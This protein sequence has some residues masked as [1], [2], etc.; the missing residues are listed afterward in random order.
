MH[1]YLTRS[2]ENYK[3]LYTLFKGINQTFSKEQFNKGYPHDQCRKSEE[4]MFHE[5]TCSV[6]NHRFPYPETSG[7]YH[8]IDTFYFRNI[9]HRCLPSKYRH[10]YAA[11]G[12]WQCQSYHD[13]SNTNTWII[14]RDCRI[15][16]QWLRLWRAGSF[17]APC[18]YIAKEESLLAT[19]WFL[20]RYPNPSPVFWLLLFLCGLGILLNQT[21]SIYTITPASNPHVHRIMIWR[22]TCLKKWDALFITLRN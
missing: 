6:S 14:A 22:S 2:Q 4:L 17:I 11:Y 5:S 9:L 16:F 21:S 18:F 7:Y 3:P 12:N 20:V 1:V 10:P 8:H 19:V 13:I 15:N